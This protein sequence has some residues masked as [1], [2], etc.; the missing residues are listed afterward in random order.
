MK[1]AIKTYAKICHFVPY[2]RVLFINPCSSDNN[3]ITCKDSVRAA[4]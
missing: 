3:L 4:Q 2:I 1:E